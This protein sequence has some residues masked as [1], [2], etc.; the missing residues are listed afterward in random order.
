MTKEELIQ[1]DSLLEKLRNERV[2]KLKKSYPDFDFEDDEALH[3]LD[4][5]DCLC[6]GIDIVSGVISYMMEEK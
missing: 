1:L 2:E 3:E 5:G 4:D 6:E